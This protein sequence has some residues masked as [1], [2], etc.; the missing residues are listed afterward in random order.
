M[1]KAAAAGAGP[2][3][4]FVDVLTLAFAG[5]LHQAQF[6]ELGDLRAGRVIMARL[7]EVFEELQLI[8]P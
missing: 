3:E 6:R 8:A 5:Q 1:A 2:A 4:Q 7:G